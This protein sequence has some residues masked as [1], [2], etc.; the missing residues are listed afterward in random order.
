MHL[1]KENALKLATA[2]VFSHTHYCNSMF[3]GLPEATLNPYQRIQNFTAKVTLGRSKFSRSANALRELH[4]LP[5]SVC[6]EYKI[7]LTVFKCPLGLAP[8]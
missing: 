4:I 1:S 7:L 5:V 2:L 3:V 6:I 8:S